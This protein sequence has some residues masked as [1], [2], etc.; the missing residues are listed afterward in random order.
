MTSADMEAVK[1]GLNSPFWRWL[2]NHVANR[3]AMLT[4]HGIES[5]LTDLGSILEREQFLGAS[6]KLLEVV[7]EVPQ[8]IQYE[9]DE[10]KAKEDENTRND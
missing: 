6:R 1:A 5:S 10:L 2:Q 9:L 3:A 8:I 7:R 4:E